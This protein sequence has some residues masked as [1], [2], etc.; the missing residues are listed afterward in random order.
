MDIVLY[1]F[2]QGCC[3]LVIF[4]CI[5]QAGEQPCTVSTLFTSPYLVQLQPSHHTFPPSPLP[6]SPRRGSTIGLYA[7][8]DDLPT[9]TQ[10][11]VMQILRGSSPRN[12]RTSP[13]QVSTVPHLTSRG[14]CSH[15][16]STHQLT[17]PCTPPHQLGL[18]PHPLH[19]VLHLEARPY[20]S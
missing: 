19:W 14:E 6:P 11:D 16:A 9:H 4:L 3:F 2:R 12:P 15:H 20:V 1:W 17:C 7:R 5:A 13:H 10:H 8:R 18:F